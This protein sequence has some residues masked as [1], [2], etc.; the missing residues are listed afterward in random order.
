[1]IINT[2]DTIDVF[3]DTDHPEVQNFL[4]SVPINVLKDGLASLKSMTGNECK[5]IILDI[6]DQKLT[7]VLPS[8]NLDIDPTFYMSNSKFAEFEQEKHNDNPYELKRQIEG[9]PLSDNVENTIGMKLS[10]R[11]KKVTDDLKSDVKFVA[12]L[13]FK[14]KNMQDRLPTSPR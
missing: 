7:A 4:Q 9:L 12:Q 6:K 1:M 2:L 14:L 8:G 3:Q 10:Y 11:E 5:K 13:I